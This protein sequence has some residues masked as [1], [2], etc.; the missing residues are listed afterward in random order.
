M[1]ETKTVAAFVPWKLKRQ[2]RRTFL[3]DE[4]ALYLDW[5][6]GFMSLYNYQNSPKWHT[7]DLCTQNK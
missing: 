5:D 3:G 7:Q 4:T 6:G 2:M 1:T